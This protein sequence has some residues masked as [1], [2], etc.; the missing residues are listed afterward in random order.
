M[1]VKISTDRMRTHFKE[2]YGRL[3]GTENRE[4][5]LRT[6]GK[7]ALLTMYTYLIASTRGLFD[8]FPFALALLAALPE[9]IGFAFAGAALGAVFGRGF[10]PAMLIGYTAIFLWRTQ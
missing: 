6:L 10:S 2:L 1:N 4:E 7:G 5:I 9:R 3:M 8:T